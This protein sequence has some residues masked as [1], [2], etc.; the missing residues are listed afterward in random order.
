MSRFQFSL[1][2][3]LNSLLA[4]LD[5]SRSSRKAV[6]EDRRVLKW[7]CLL[8][9]LFTL[10]AFGM[11]DVFAASCPR[12]NKGVVIAYYYDSSGTVVEV[13]AVTR[14]IRTRSLQQVTNPSSFPEPRDPDIPTSLVVTDQNVEVPSAA[15]RA[16][17][18]GPKNTSEPG[19]H[20]FVAKWTEVQTPTTHGRGIKRACVSPIHPCPPPTT[21]HSCARGCCCW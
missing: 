1:A 12:H 16:V 2:P 8:A 18:Y 17:Y 5:V 6:R 19:C 7:R 20:E 21:C 15:V 10:S 4:Y 13:E 11:N 3:T 14:K 9:A